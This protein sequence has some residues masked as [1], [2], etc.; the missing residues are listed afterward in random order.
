M[1]LSLHPDSRVV[2]ASFNWFVSLDDFM[3]PLDS[4]MMLRSTR[5]QRDRF[6]DEVVIGDVFCCS[7][8]S[9][10]DTGLQL[11]LLCY[12]CKRSREI[13]QLKITAHCSSRDIPELLYGKSKEVSDVYS[14]KDKVTGMCLRVCYL[15]Y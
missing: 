14:V 10:S 11:A 3:P 9:V 13:D 7:V 1:T 8:M 15:L 12:A 2:R 4:M 5:L 6:Y